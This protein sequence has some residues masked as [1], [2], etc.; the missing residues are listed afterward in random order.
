MLPSRGENLPVAILEAM[1]V[2]LPVVATRVGGV[3][4]VVRDGESGLLVEPEDVEGLAAALARLAEGE[5]RERLGRAAAARIAEHFEAG[6][7][8]RQMVA[9]YRELVS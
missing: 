6:L 8:A 3:P 1:A 7:V 5:E 2:A 9:L 4:E